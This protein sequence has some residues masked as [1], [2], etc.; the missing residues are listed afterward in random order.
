MKALTNEKDFLPNVM[1]P[2]SCSEYCFKGKHG[3]W[4]LVIQC[5]LLKV[6]LP[7]IDKSR[8]LSVQHMWDQYDRED[9]DFDTI[10]LNKEWEIRPSIVISETGCPQVLHAVITEVVLNIRSCIRLIIQITTSVPNTPI[11]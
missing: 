5:L 6:L 10:L 2:F 4:D 7:H 1:C 8:Y 11:S 9:D 3:T